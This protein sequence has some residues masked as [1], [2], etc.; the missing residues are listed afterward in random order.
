M[1]AAQPIF[2]SATEAARQLR[3]PVWQIRK[4]FDRG[5]LP[6]PPRLGPYRVILPEDLPRIADAL[7]RAGYRSAESDKTKQ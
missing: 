1:V 2:L 4:I 5:L 7:V 6:Q 3:C